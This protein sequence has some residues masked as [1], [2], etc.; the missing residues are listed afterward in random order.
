MKKLL[1]CLMC[2]FSVCGYAQRK[3]I[4]DE[5]CGVRFGESY[6]SAK[7]ILQNKFGSPDYILTDENQIV[8]NYK[9][10]SGIIFSE[11]DFCFQRN[12]NNSYM[13]QCIMGIDCRTAQEAKEYRDEI[14]EKVEPIYNG[15]HYAI[16]GNGFRFYEGGRSPLGGLLNG[17]VVD[18]VKF[19]RP[20]KGYNYFARI[21]YG[22]YDYV[23]EEF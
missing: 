23:N 6:E 4:C 18:V 8:Y 20:Y 13:N 14:W 7:E 22:P 11:I 9:T 16:D 3:S 12:G 1:L 15:Y 10:Y 17:F 5:I 2:L 21:M 19:K